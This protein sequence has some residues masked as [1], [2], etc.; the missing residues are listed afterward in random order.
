[1]TT[2]NIP[3]NT[4]SHYPLPSL[5]DMNSISTLSNGYSSLVSLS[6][7][8]KTSPK[9][10]PHH[11]KTQNP[12]QFLQERLHTQHCFP[13]CIFFVSTLPSCHSLCWYFPIF[14]IHTVCHSQHQKLV[15]VLWWWVLHPGSTWVWGHYGAWGENGFT[16]LFLY[17]LWLTKELFGRTE[18]STFCDYNSMKFPVL[19]TELWYQKVPVW[20]F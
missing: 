12:L 13:L 16:Q 1:M 7:P 2:T 11:P 17:I 14:K 5:P 8:L 18:N 10:K 20:L 15:S 19:N 9:P 4:H 6:T 3:P